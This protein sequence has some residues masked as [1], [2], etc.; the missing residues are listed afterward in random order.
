MTSIDR[1]AEVAS[2]HGVVVS[3][4]TLALG[5]GF[6]AGYYFARHRL[7]TQ[8]QE[9]ANKDIETQ[10]DAARKHFTVIQA[11]D[12]KPDSPADAVEK[13]IPE[14][15]DALV[16]Y[17]TADVQNILASYKGSIGKDDVDEEGTFVAQRSRSFRLEDEVRRNN[18]WGDDAQLMEGEVVDFDYQ[19][20]IAA[21][22]DDIPYIISEEEYLEN[23]PDFPQVQL[24]YFSNDDVTIDAQD[25]IV[26]DLERWVGRKNLR[27][28]HRSGD[29]RIVFVRNVSHGHDFCV[30]QHEG[31]YAEA[32]LGFVKENAD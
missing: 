9:N 28:G 5:A 21:R 1:L 4:S 29:N 31:S 19:E 15:A 26:E 6:L 30:V 13:L 2:K 10:V 32:M 16:E 8:I 23:G 22:T 12:S 17:V 20:E 25:E 18:V 11:S 3:A 14:A 27:F 24:T 7:E